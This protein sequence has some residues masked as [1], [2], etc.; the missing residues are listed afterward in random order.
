MK[1]QLAILILIFISRI[2]L[3]Q[4]Y[5]E[6]QKLLCYLDQPVLS[7]GYQLMDSNTEDR[8]EQLRIDKNEI[9]VGHR[10]PVE[11]MQKMR[12]FKVS[13]NDSQ[14][15]L[16][17]NGQLYRVTIKSCWYSAEAFL[18]TYLIYGLNIADPKTEGQPEILAVAE[19][20]RIDW[21]FSCS[22]YGSY[23]A[24]FRIRSNGIGD[25]GLMIVVEN[26]QCDY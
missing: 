23:D 25:Q 6:T 16:I 24:D 21:A 20:N 11:V 5:D 12:C 3:C 10:K 9:N 17:K 13:A 4:S 26:L 22:L 14:S 8:I 2:M 7:E 15:I 18:G 19:T 1:T